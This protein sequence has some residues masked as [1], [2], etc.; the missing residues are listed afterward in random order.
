[1]SR[2]NDRTVFTP[3]I[4]TSDLAQTEDR[5]TYWKQILPEAHVEYVDQ[6][7]VSRTINFDKGY[8]ED[9]IQSFREHAI[10][11]TC[12][13]LATPSNNH[14]RDFDPERQRADVQDLA[15]YE[16]LPEDVKAKVGTAPG[17]YAKMRFFSKKAARAVDQNPNLGVSARVRE[18]FTRAD[19]KFVKRAII[20]VLGTIDPRVTGMSSWAAADLSYD[21]DHGFVLDLSEAQYERNDMSPKNEDQDTSAAPSGDEIEAMTDEELDTFLA[22]SAK[23]LGIEYIPVSDQADDDDDDDLENDDDEDDHEDA[24]DARTPELQGASLSTA[25]SGAVDLANAQAQQA[26][27]RALEALTRQAKAEWREFRSGQIALGVPPAIVD[28]AQPVLA[29]PDEMVVDLSNTNEDDVNVSAILRKLI[30]GYQGTVDMS[31]ESGHSGTVDLSSQDDP[32][33]PLL[34]QWAEQ[35]PS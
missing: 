1:M 32:D 5:L 3:Q 24:A 20:H 26:N 16:D 8:H 9:L 35:F 10:D 33:Q 18:N 31:G 12:F 21:P 25:T 22:E 7:G 14:G 28:L 4:T 27:A 2:K 29:R 6:T 23:A 17:L 19:G 34:D 15:R 11:Q 30:E 13:Q